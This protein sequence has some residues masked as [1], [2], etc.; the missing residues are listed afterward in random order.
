[1][2]IEKNKN[3]NEEEIKI[4]ERKYREH[5][6]IDKAP[7]I[8]SILLSIIGWF[9][10]QCI[11]GFMIAFSSEI[12]EK[13]L[14]LNLEVTYAMMFIETVLV[15]FIGLLF[16]KRWFKS[17]FA[18]PIKYGQCRRVIVLVLAYAVYLMFNVTC[19]Y[20]TYKSLKMPNM[21]L[22]LVALSAVVTEE[23]AFRGFAVTTLMRNN[24]KENILIPV[25]VPAIAF[26]LIHATNIFAG[27]DPI[28]TV[29]QVF[30]TFG[31]GVALGGIYLLSGNILLPMVIHLIHD[32]I[33]LSSGAYK[34]NGVFAGTAHWSSFIGLIPIGILCAFILYYL[35]RK[36][37]KEAIIEIWNKKWSKDKVI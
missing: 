21:G 27:A 5:K 3:E 29:I 1:M 36:K 33:G 4:N 10:L 18:G 8:S 9:V 26:G 32:I 7:I 34:D 16:Y 11:L 35:T 20:L 24:K 13:P 23:C 22:L 14:N 12:I 31:M 6:L 30:V 28:F 15:A 2:E 19:I 17:D 25:I 37:N